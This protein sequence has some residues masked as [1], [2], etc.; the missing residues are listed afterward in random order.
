M[1]L[2]RWSPRSGPRRAAMA[3]NGP[4]RKPNGSRLV[5]PTSLV[6][7]N[8]GRDLWAVQDLNL[9]PLPCQGDP[10]AAWACL[11]MPGRALHLAGLCLRVPGGASKAA[12]NGSRQWLPLWRL[13]F[14]AAAQLMPGLLKLGHDTTSITAAAVPIALARA[15]IGSR[16]TLKI[17]RRRPAG[18]PGRHTQGSD[19]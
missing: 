11:E 10:L 1:G 18:R 12:E 8:Y 17:G 3:R 14:P 4:A 19:F 6:I 16:L 13:G 9:W 2:S 7:S 15:K 5:S